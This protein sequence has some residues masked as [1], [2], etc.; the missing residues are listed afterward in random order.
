MY[1]KNANLVDLTYYNKYITNILK[2]K[3]L[4]TEFVE[5]YYCF[6]YEEN[7]F[8]HLHIFRKIKKHEGY[9]GFYK[10]FRV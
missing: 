7:I 1:Q 4:T 5:H 2:I 3:Y 8:L 10:G 6:D 9:K